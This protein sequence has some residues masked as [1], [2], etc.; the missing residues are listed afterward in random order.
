MNILFALHQFGHA[1]YWTIRL[2]AEIIVVVY[3]GA[4]VAWLFSRRSH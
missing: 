2:T 1:L 4:F 3:L